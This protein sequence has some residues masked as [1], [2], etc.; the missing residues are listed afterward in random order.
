MNERYTHISIGNINVDIAVY[1]EKFPSPGESIIASDLDIRPGGAASN[2]AVAVAQ[3]GHR[4]YLLASTSSSEFANVVVNELKSKGVIVDRVKIVEDSFPGLVLIL[5]QR[6]GERT[7]VKYPGANRELTASD[8][9]LDLV[10]DAH[11]VHMASISPELALEI[12]K[13]IKSSGAIITYDP[14]AYAD[15]MITG[16]MENI[17][18]LFINEKELQELKKAFKVSTLFKHGLSMLVVK[19]GERGAVVITPNDVC[20]HGKA[21]SIKKPVDSTGAGDAFDAFFNAKFIESKDPSLALR[22]GVA[23][24]ALKVGYKGSFLPFDVKLFNLQ[25]EKVLVEKT[26]ECGVIN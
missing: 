13:R 25:L 21:Q 20:I 1:I 15:F 10:R 4:V 2:Y 3:Y 8:V 11:V 16:L 26:G 9:P 17:D 7:M 24:G 6:S 22:Y 18:I 12:S 19:M 5:V 23:A 14:G